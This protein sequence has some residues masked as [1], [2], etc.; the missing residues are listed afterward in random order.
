MTDVGGVEPVSHVVFSPGDFVDVTATLDVVQNREGRVHVR[1]NL[2][3]MTR[4]IS[5]VQL[6][7]RALLAPL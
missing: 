1:L 4:L 7:R 6:V 2:E 5:V 3:R